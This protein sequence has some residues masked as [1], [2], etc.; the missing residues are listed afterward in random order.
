VR[1]AISAPLRRAAA[2]LPAII[3]CC[4]L[5]VGQSWG[6]DP[7]PS[8]AE[9]TTDVRVGVGGGF[10]VGRW[11]PLDVTLGGVAPANARLEVDAPDPDGALVT[12]H[13]EPTH[14][15]PTHSEPK[16]PAAAA[17]S[18][19]PAGTP[20]AAPL[21]L[22]F[23]MGRLDGMLR[24]RV[25]DGERVVTN[26]TVRVS[27]D[28]DADVHT[29]SRLSV[30]LVANVQAAR[31][32]AS[33]TRSDITRVSQFLTAGNNNTPNAAS[34]PRTEVVD[35]DSFRS[36]PTRPDAYD[37]FD[38]V[39]ITE[40]F[41][42]DAARSRALQDWVRSGGHLLIAIG[43]DATDFAKTSPA[44]AAWL[45][46]TIEGTTKLRDLSPIESFCRQSS[47]IMGA[48]DEPLEAAKLKAPG[49]KE[50]IPS[51]AGPLLCRAAYG[52]GRVTVFG[53]DL[54]SPPLANWSAA[55]DLLE[56]LFD[57]D[58]DHAQHMI[59]VS[60][61]LTQTGIT[62]LATQLDGS[63]D[64][65]PNVSRFTIWHVMGLL[66][67]LVLIVGPLDYLLV[68]K[69][70]H[71]PELTWVTLPLI[72][73]LAAGAAFYWSSESKGKQVLLNQ[74]DIFDVDAT[75]GW[76]RAHSYGVLYSPENRRYDITA[77]ADVPPRVQASSKSVQAPRLG[78]HGRPEANFGGMYRTAGVEI[79]HPSYSA[80]AGDRQLEQMPISVWSTKNL[81][82][83][84]SQDTTGLIDS[85]LESR[86]PSHLG[87]SLRHHFPG[88]IEDWVVA[89]GHQV[90]YPRP[91][92]QDHLLPMLPDVPW[93]PQTAMQRE[94]SGYLTGA[95]QTMVTTQGT[96][97]EE[98]RT[99][100]VDYDPLNHDPLFI[101]RMLT[102]HN[103]AGGTLYTGLGNGAL[104]QFDWSPLLELNRAVLVGRVRRPLTRWQVDGQTVDADQSYSLV[105]VVLP[106]KPV[107]YQE[108]N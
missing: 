71:R 107:R 94:L 51:L 83:E 38:A 20:A 7:A 78:W 84:W 68:H 2:A 61:R 26:K 45:P 18:A 96:H 4:C 72:A 47:R 80:S 55:P 69:L 102:F 65:F 106:V 5:P 75:S 34:A 39:L 86:G 25:L 46:V 77:Q 54:S 37:A 19:G 42:L 41:D 108:E 60:N 30:L 17:N 57:V 87:G 49:G 31:D 16:D 43:R 40:R 23:K 66:V 92:T 22:L 59:S 52:L 93:A 81:E 29:P 36:L 67:A 13:S 73:L 91:D 15:E 95:T 27:G 3:L 8:S 100:H 101:L 103:E 12:Y 89:Y 10:K 90:F 85:Q 88:P 11:A 32:V 21:S 74:L 28:P 62:E 82:S 98:M 9:A 53:L 33:S 79:S 44:L 58:Q 63:L 1:H 50:L 97:L 24:V 70:L 48:T 35:I 14:G 64:E 105:R 56:R 6:G 99:E 104:R 76:G